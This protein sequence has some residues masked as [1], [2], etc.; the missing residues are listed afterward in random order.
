MSSTSFTGIAA[1]ACVSIRQTLL[2]L[3]RPQRPMNARAP[4]QQS[5]WSG[6]KRSTAFA[7]FTAFRSPGFVDCID[8]AHSIQ[9]T[10]RHVE[11]KRSINDALAM[12][13]GT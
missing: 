12:T 6:K 13:Q 10:G 3:R 1:C 8:D 2:R 9:S 7:G 11:G 5:E 4:S